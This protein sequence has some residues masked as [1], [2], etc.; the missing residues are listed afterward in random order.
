MDKKASTSSE[1]LINPENV[2]FYKKILVEFG[3]IPQLQPAAKT[4]TELL[5]Y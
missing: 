1:Q 2:D 3:K 5:N 4:I